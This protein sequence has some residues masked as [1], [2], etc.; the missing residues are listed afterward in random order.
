M[1]PTTRAARRLPPEQRQAQLTEAALSVAAEQG[2]ANLSLEDV[3]ARAGVTRNLLYRYFPRGRLDVFLA[4]VE[5]SSEELTGEWSLDS[6]EA[7]D[8]RL[9]RNFLRLVEHAAG[10]TDAWRVA[11]HARAAAGEQEIAAANDRMRAVVVANV[12]LNHFGTTEPGPLALLALRAYVDFAETALEQW[13][14]S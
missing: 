5:R 9:A 6:G 4:A 3:A 8:E 13:R 11:R 7:L 1:A 12:A 14:D 10:P 2:Y